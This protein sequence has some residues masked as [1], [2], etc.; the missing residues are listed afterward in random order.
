MPTT[1]TDFANELNNVISGNNTFSGSSTFTGTV[2]L[3]LT[4]GNAVSLL[5]AQNSANQITG[6][7]QAA[8]LYTWTMPASTV[9][10][11]KGFRLTAVFNHSLG[12]AS[13]SYLASLNGVGLYNPSNTGGGVQGFQITSSKHR[14]HNWYSGRICMGRITVVHSWRKSYRACLGIKS[15][16]QSHFHGG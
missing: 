8:T 4:S 11:L 2:T 10:N 12:S 13:V 1:V 15:G 7:G 9:G 5:N 6:T 16:A 14:E 3:S